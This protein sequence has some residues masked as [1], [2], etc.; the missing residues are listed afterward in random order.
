MTMSWLRPRRR[1]PIM[2][3]MSATE[4]G[5]ACLAMVFSSYR[6]WTSVAECREQLGIGRDGATALQMT[7]LARRTGMRARG[8]LRRS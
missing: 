2:L 6:R 5:A 1:V 4:C 3:Q 8:S 7:Q